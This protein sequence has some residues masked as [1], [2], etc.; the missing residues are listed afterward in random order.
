MEE[1]VDKSSNLES[2]PFTSPVRQFDGCAN[3]VFWK[4]K[5]EVVI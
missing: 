3:H 5:K 2:D 4:N 1:G